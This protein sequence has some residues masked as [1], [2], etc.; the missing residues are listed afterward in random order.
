MSV[1]YLTL[2][3]QKLNQKRVLIREDL[4]VPLKNGE[5]TDDT[6]IQAALPTLRYALSQN[7]AVLVMSHLGRPEEG[8]FDAQLSLAPVAKALSKALETEVVLVE[9]WIEGVEVLPGQIVLCENVRFLQGEEKNDSTLAKKMA[10]LCD[11]FVMDA[12]ATA[13]RAQASTVGVAKYAPIACAGPLLE[14]ELNA[15]TLAFE[16]PAHPVVTIIGG[17]KISTKMPVLEALLDKTNTLIVGGGIANTFLAAT[18]MDVG[19][20]LYEP[21]WLEPARALLQKAEQKG[22]YIPLPTDVKVA[23]KWEETAAATTKSLADIQ[24]DEMILDVGP[25]TVASYVKEILAAKT[26]VWNG[27]LGVFE[28]PAFAEGTRLLGEA[29]GQ[30]AAFSMAGGGD[31]LSALAK[32]HLTAKVSYVSTGGGAFLEFMEGKTLPAVEI[33]KQRAGA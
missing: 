14:A 2:F 10:D 26:I 27:P 29:I 6:R 15:L 28:F 20:S 13:H 19:K 33:L 30:S 17:S 31:T 12:F 8:H 21:N 16:H 23:I 1:A 5:I 22:V 4:N 11:I 24:R 32:F 7:A 18:G 25:K 3:A 9:N